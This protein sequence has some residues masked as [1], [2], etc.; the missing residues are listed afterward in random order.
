MDLVLSTPS[1]I[2]GGLFITKESVRAQLEQLNNTNSRGPDAIQL[3]VFNP[4]RD[5]F[6]GPGQFKP[7]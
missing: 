4:L 6:A 2:I 5:V 7:E 3:A 1:H